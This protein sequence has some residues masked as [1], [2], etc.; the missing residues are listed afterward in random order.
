MKLTGGHVELLVAGGRGSRLDVGEGVLAARKDVALASLQVLR[1]GHGV[2][3]QDKNEREPH[4]ER[5]RFRPAPRG[6]RTGMCHCRRAEPT[7][8]L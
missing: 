4:K 5:D 6:R 7:G 1:D 2:D 3:G 8:R